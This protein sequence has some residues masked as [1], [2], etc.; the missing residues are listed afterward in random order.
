MAHLDLIHLS[1]FKSFYGAHE[2][3]PLGPFTAI[4]GANGIGKSVIG[5]AIAFACG[6]SARQL[7]GNAA[8]EF[9]NERRRREVA[10]ERENQSVDRRARKAPRI[11]QNAPDDAW[12]AADR[13]DPSARSGMIPE[14]RVELRFKA[15]AAGDGDDPAREQLAVG[16]SINING[17]SHYWLRRGAAAGSLGERRAVG[18]AEL[19]S[20]T[21]SLLGINIE[22]PERCARRDATATQL[23]VG[24]GGRPC[25][26]SQAT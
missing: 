25:W 6:A 22:A 23:N 12:D 17:A 5:E 11:K 15:L 21:R 18:L 26:L 20:T 9:I 19:R 1:N 24:M 13:D 2:I 8:A 3:G 7:R 4:I 10:A 16:R 14:A